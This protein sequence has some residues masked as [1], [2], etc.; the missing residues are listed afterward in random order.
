EQCTTDRELHHD[1]STAP[2]PCRNAQ[3]V[4]TAGFLNRAPKILSEDCEQREQSG[5]E[6]RE[7]R[8]SSSSAHDTPVE[9]ELE[10]VAR[11]LETERSH[12]RDA[13]ERECQSTARSCNGE[14]RAFDQQKPCEPPRA[15]TKRRT[16]SELFAARRHARKLQIC[17][18][19]AGDQ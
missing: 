15:S 16:H 4:R 13:A 7:Q 5:Q 3:A 6:R 2:T 19:R 14:E 11:T 10:S 18:V 1:E 17:D 9:R 12:Q 8:C